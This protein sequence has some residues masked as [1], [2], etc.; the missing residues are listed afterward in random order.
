MESDFLELRAVKRTMGW[1]RG[2]DKITS[3]PTMRRSDVVELA[4]PPAVV[5][6]TTCSLLDSRFAATTTTTTS[7]LLLLTYAFPKKG[8]RRPHMILSI[9]LP[10]MRV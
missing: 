2:E 8:S 4:E 5:L 7:H 3:I 10:L 6:P 9:A 1:R